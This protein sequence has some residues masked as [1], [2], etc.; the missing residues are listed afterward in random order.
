MS[1]RWSPLPIDSFIFH[2]PYII[3]IIIN[4]NVLYIYR[5]RERVIFSFTRYLKRGYLH[6][7]W[8][9]TLCAKSYKALEECYTS[10][11]SISFLLYFNPN[12]L[13]YAQHSNVKSN[14]FFSTVKHSLFWKKKKKVTWKAKL[15]RL[16]VPWSSLS[17]FLNKKR[18]L[19]QVLFFLLHC[20]HSIY[21]FIFNRHQIPWVVLRYCNIGYTVYVNLCFLFAGMLTEKAASIL[22]EV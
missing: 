11:S 18:S 9:C 8:F 20:P 22:L 13:K 2:V 4:M 16:N 15:R 10:Y 1:C 3:H 17:H 12:S 6:Y 19:F 7:Y 14:H 21:L 5:E